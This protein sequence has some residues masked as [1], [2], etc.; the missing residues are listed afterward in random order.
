MKILIVDD[1]ILVL[2]ILELYL[3]TIGYDNVHCVTSA[4][5][6]LDLI[7]S[8]IHPFQVIL[9]D[10]SM[11]SRSGIELIPLIQQQ[12]GYRQ[13]PIVMITAMNDR[14]YIATAFVAGAFDYVTKPFEFSELE[15]KLETAKKRS[16]AFQ[17]CRSADPGVESDLDHFVRHFCAAYRPPKT[18][19]AR[20]S[21][22]LG[23][24]EFENCLQ[25]IHAET[26]SA[27]KPMTL[28]IQ[29]AS[30]LPIE[31][32]PDGPQHYLTVLAAQIATQISPIWGIATYLGDCTF[33]AAAFGT[34]PAGLSAA[35]RKAVALSDQAHA[36]QLTI[37][38]DD[39]PAQESPEQ[40]MIKAAPPYLAY[41]LQK[42]LTE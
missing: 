4:D 35:L 23:E 3:G 7:Q 25:R 14:K 22:L 10:I 26:A 19:L 39:T 29:G 16:K 33:V 12:P 9:L 20:D 13:T 41:R 15:A 24:T 2:E 18:Q 38:P 37:A 27:P 34:T 6:A 11:P 28:H 8:S 30:A 32:G 17:F 42:Q 21:G 40:Q 5:L 1:D 36:G 31:Q